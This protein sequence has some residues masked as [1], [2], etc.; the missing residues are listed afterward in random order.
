MGDIYIDEMNSL[1]Y[2]FLT[3]LP[4]GEMVGNSSGTPMNLPS[5]GEDDGVVVGF[6]LPARSYASANLGDYIIATP[7]LGPPLLSLLGFFFHLFSEMLWWIT[8]N[9]LTV[10]M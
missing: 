6:G 9:P 8:K 3:A 1:V 7:F 5:K 10:F 2:L 4:W